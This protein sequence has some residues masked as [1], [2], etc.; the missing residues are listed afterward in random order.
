MAIWCRLHLPPGTPLSVTRLIEVIKLAAAE[1]YRLIAGIQPDSKTFQAL[2]QT[3]AEFHP[4]VRVVERQNPKTW[5][6]VLHGEVNTNFR[7]DDPS[8]PLWKI[9]MIVSPKVAQ[10]YRA[11]FGKKGGQEA[12]EVNVESPE[13]TKAEGDGPVDLD[14]DQVPSTETQNNSNENNTNTAAVQGEYFEISF[15]FHHCLGD[16]LSMWAFGR[17]FLKY[18]KQEYF[19]A[20]DLEL[21]RIPLSKEP[22]P[23]LDNLMNP[24][25]FEILPGMHV[26]VLGNIHLFME[27]NSRLGSHHRQSIQKKTSALQR[28]ARIPTQGEHSPRTCRHS[29]R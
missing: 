7:M 2:G 8:I 12:Q 5:L 4:I 9:A 17:T 18:A 13:I 11:S 15:S 25:L 27:K 23:I 3:A 26:N 22:P 16:G 19:L 6:S 28:T 20:K 10:E 24:S 14:K 21:S 1:H 29:C